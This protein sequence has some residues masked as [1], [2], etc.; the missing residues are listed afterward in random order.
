MSKKYVPFWVKSQYSRGWFV[1]VLILLAIMQN[2]WHAVST[3]PCLG[4]V[5]VVRHPDGKQLR[6]VLWITVPGYSPLTHFC[7]SG[8]Q[9]IKLYYPHSGWPFT[10]QL[11]QLRR[12]PI[13]K[14]TGQLALDSHSWNPLPMWFC[15]ARWQLN[16]TNYHTSQRR[17]PSVTGIY[18]TF[19]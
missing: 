16:L 19:V 15:V 17:L 4:S 18:R 13:N 7:H 2:S 1:M 11:T 12:I 10:P 6:K 3:V 8:A 5:A 9:S 14:P